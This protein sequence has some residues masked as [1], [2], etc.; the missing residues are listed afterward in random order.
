MSSDKPWNAAHTLA[1]IADTCTPEPLEG[2]KLHAFFIETAEA[3]DEKTHLRKRLLAIFNK[4]DT[5]PRRVL[6]YGHRG[7]GKSTELNR[8]KQ[9]VGDAWFIADF[10]V[11]DYLPPVGVTAEDILLAIAVALSEKLNAKDAQPGEERPVIEIGRKHLDPIY[12]FF[13]DLTITT[14]EERDAKLKTAAEAGVG[15]NPIWSL[16]FQLKASVG[17]ELSFGSKNEESRIQKIRQRPGDLILAVNGLLLAVEEALKAQGRKLMVIVEDLDK[18]QLADAHKVFVENNHLLAKLNTNLI[19]TIPIFTFYTDN[20]DAIRAQFDEELHLQM[21][22]IIER[23]GTVAPGYAKVKE[24]ILK[25]VRPDVIADDALDLLIRGTGGVLR[26]V[27]EALQL[28]STYT[29]LRGG[30]IEE[31][32]IR[33]ALNKIRADIG[34]AI[35]WPRD[36]E[37][38]QEKPEPLYDTLRECAATQT[39]GGIFPPR[40]DPAIHVLLRSCALIEYNGERWLGVHPLAWEYL[41]QIGRDPGPNPFGI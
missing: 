26:H 7:C 13:A 36:R 19:Y 35:G 1:E 39:A 31:K 24:I 17:S 12:R 28:V 15:T 25:R 6:L 21:I 18:L 20:A 37:G 23:D 22:K 40:N 11:R 4:D 32:N 2:E 41:A 30:R 34:I 5:R 33:D 29:N 16:I 3:R 8:F 38:K 14:T 9:E 10:S 27:F